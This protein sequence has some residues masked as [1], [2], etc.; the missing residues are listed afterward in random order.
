MAHEG[1]QRI[2]KSKE[3]LQTKVWWP[4][5]NQDMAKRCAECYGCQLVTRNV[6]PQP[7]KPI[8]LSKQ[9][10][11]EVAMDLLGRFLLYKQHLVQSINMQSDSNKFVQN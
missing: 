7:V 1:C 4:R 8:V 6:Q 10:W 5:M 9:P 11:E 2:V 3:R